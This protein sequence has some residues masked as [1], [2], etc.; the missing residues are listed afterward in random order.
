VRDAFW[1]SADAEPFEGGGSVGDWIRGRASESVTKRLQK[2]GVE[3]ISLKGLDPVWSNRLADEL[4]KEVGLSGLRVRTLE[5]YREENNI[6]M[7]TIEDRIR[8]NL[9]NLTRVTLGAKK[10]VAKLYAGDPRLEGLLNAGKTELPH[11]V[12]NTAGTIEDAFAMNLLHEFGHVLVNAGRLA[13]TPY[14]PRDVV[15]AT[16]L[17]GNEELL[18]ENFVLY[19]MGR[20]VSDAMRIYLENTL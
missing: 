5:T 20:A 7:E 13:Q 12:A 16:C 10:D 18:M 19:R 6:G 9:H 17:L 2:A 8:I 1:K 11:A 4:E 14:S 15:S 3:N